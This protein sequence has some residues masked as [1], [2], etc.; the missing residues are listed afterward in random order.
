[1]FDNDAEKSALGSG[2]MI[3]WKIALEELT[4]VPILGTG[5]DALVDGLKENYTDDY[6]KFIVNTHMQ[7]DKAHNEYLQIAVT[8]G[9]PALIV[10]LTFIAQ[11]LASARKNIFKNNATFILFIPIVSYLVQ[12]FFNISTIGVAPVFWALLGLIQ[13][14]QFK[15]ELLIDEFKLL[16]DK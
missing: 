9:I 1:M 7:I 2:R 4:F 11:I 13:S 14:Q 10:Y 8:L 3:I 12:A 5:P 15:N 6:V 16:E